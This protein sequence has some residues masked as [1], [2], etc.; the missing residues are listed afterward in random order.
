MCMD[1]QLFV[2]L[3]DSNWEKVRDP[4]AT[5]P[6]SIDSRSKAA[7]PFTVMGSCLRPGASTFGCFHLLVEELFAPGKPDCL[8]LTEPAEYDSARPHRP[9]QASRGEFWVVS[10]SI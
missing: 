5:T 2:G 1:L 4:V 7:V 9:L 10:W 6:I 8:C 3:R